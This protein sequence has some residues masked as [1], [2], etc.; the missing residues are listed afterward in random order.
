MRQLPMRPAQ[1]SRRAVAIVLTLTV[2]ATFLY[3]L[4]PAFSAGQVNSG[5]QASAPCLAEP[6][7]GTATW[8]VVLGQRAL[9]S[10]RVIDAGSSAQLRFGMAGLPPAP[11]QFAIGHR[12]PGSNRAV[13]AA[14]GAQNGPAGDWVECEITYTPVHSAVGKT[15]PRRTDS[16]VFHKLSLREDFGHLYAKLGFTMA[17]LTYYDI[18]THCFEP[19]GLKGNCNDCFKLMFGGAVGA[20]GIISAKYPKRQSV[21]VEECLS[22][23]AAIRAKNEALPNYDELP[24]TSVWCMRNS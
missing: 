11:G 19:D 24:E 21:S 13:A 5:Q 8:P 17:G 6:Q 3:A 23:S 12:L 15:E 18:K 16:Y 2:G 14:A 20:T 1:C 22:D 9:L 10:S 7:L 4:S